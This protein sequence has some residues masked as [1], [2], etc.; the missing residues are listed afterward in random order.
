M[1]STACTLQGYRWYNGGWSEKRGAS[2]LYGGYAGSSSY[3]TRLY[4]KTPAVS[5]SYT[6]TKLK[7]TIP[8]VKQTQSATSGHLYA[9]LT[10][11]VE[12]DE[13]ALY[14]RSI[15]TIP[16]ASNCDGSGTW[17]A[18]DREVHTMTI[19]IN[20]AV[21]PNTE[22]YITIGCNINYLEIGHAYDNAT[23]MYAASLEY[24]SYTN[25]SVS[26]PTI[27]DNGNNTFTI[28]GSYANGTNNK[29]S[30]GKIYY[31]TNG[32]NP[33]T[34]SSSI[35]ISGATINVPSGSSSST[36]KAFAYGTFAHNTDSSG[37][38]SKT[39]Y[40]YTN[41]SSPT[42]SITDNGNNTFTVSGKL[43]SNGW[44]NGLS[45]ATLYFT[46]NGNNPDSGQSWTT[47]VNLTSSG[48]G[49]SYS[50]TYN[51]PAGCTTVK[52]ITYCAFSRNTT[53]SGNVSVSVKYHT[54]IGSPAIKITDNY[55]NTFTIT[56]TNAASGTNNTANTAFAWGYSTSYGNSGTGTKTLSIA[57]SSNATRTVYAKATA[58]PSWNG[59]SVKTATTS[60]AIKQYVAPSNPG[61]PVISYTRNRLTIKENWTF[62]WS[63]AGAT[64]TS[65]PVKGY[66]I[67]LLKNG[68]SVPIKNTSGTVISTGTDWCVIDSTSTSITIS[69]TKNDFKPGDTVRI[70]VRPYTQYGSSNTGSQLFN[71][72]YTYSATYT[73]QNAGIVRVK[74]DGTWRE[75]QVYVKVDGSWREA[76]TVNVKADGVWKESQ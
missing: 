28:S 22:Y 74:P 68:V 27:K 57:T 8:F 58:T 19:T 1:A 37:I 69:P 34:S 11:Y 26:T 18:S 52:A 47:A 51:I 46:T 64:N 36:V 49:G 20:K 10:K 55:N 32:S 76:E 38:A 29:L 24:T 45:S 6:G 3:V 16:N 41:G 12:A 75:G 44:N 48:S 5:G 43:G 14:S 33:T 65:S 70:G 53:H 71:A 39:V 7:F 66:R 54:A 30:S 13:P 62:S 61:T 42:L 56:G 9:I 63:A 50:K 25:G 23:S 2:K 40:Y 31:T 4:F 67:V 60:L 73:V 72:D 15:G 21:K 59:D 17:S 35:A